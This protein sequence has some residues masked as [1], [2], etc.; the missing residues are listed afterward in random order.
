M[1]LPDIDIFTR[2]KILREKIAKPLHSITIKHPSKSG[3]LNEVGKIF[4]YLLYLNKYTLIT[5]IVDVEASQYFRTNRSKMIGVPYFLTLKLFSKHSI[6]SLLQAIQKIIIIYNKDWHDKVTYQ[7]SLGI[8]SFSLVPGNKL[9]F[10]SNIYLL[11]LLLDQISRGKSFSMQ[12]E[13]KDLLKM[14]NIGT[15]HK[16][17]SYVDALDNLCFQINKLVLNRDRVGK[18]EMNHAKMLCLDPYR[19]T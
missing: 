8:F 5:M 18:T 4:P 16:E 2:L 7:N 17:Y 14:D 12:S 6:D 11:S 19:E 3:K 10:P 1:I 9:S 13:T 15:D